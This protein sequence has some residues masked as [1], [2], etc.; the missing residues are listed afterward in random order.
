MWQV[1]FSP[2]TAV[3]SAS[4]GMPS[5]RFNW[6]TP[7]RM[8]FRRLRDSRDIK[9]GKMASLLVCLRRGIIAEKA[10]LG[11]IHDRNIV[12][13]QNVLQEGRMPYCGMKG[14]VVL[15]ES[16][17][18]GRP[19]SQ[20]PVQRGIALADSNRRTV[21]NSG[22]LSGKAGLKGV[23]QTPLAG[24]CKGGSPCYRRAMPAGSSP[25]TT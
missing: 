13:G 5:I 22:T 8:A 20:M 18:F 2:N 4:S 17:G 1:P 24:S 9:S 23:A 15:S 11:K 16:M 3:L 7:S 25:E 6:L 10:G 12:S 19:A 21:S 14:T